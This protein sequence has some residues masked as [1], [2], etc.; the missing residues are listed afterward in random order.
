MQKLRAA[1]Q[2]QH[3]ALRTASKHKGYQHHWFSADV[4]SFKR[5]I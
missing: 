4:V 3:N 2:H 1:I 5:R